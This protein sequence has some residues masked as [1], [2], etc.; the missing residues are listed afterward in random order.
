MLLPKLNMSIFPPADARNAEKKLAPIIFWATHSPSAIIVS[1]GCG[2]HEMAA[3]FHRLVL[4]LT[5]GRE[6]RL[7][8]APYS[9]KYFNGI[10]E[11]S[12]SR[13][14]PPQGQ[15]IICNL[16]LRIALMRMSCQPIIVSRWILS[17]GRLWVPTPMS[18]G[19]DCEE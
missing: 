16:R 15:P 6:S 4:L 19:K 17:D 13:P 5:T 3:S 12:D 11:N 9:S 1:S 18:P 14:L 10:R 8:E 7:R 2:C